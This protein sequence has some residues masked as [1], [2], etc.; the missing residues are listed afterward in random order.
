MGSRW[1]V[2][3]SKANLPFKRDFIKLRGYCSALLHRRQIFSNK[4]IVDCKLNHPILLIESYGLFPTAHPLS[5]ANCLQFSTALQPFAKMPHRDPHQLYT[6]FYNVLHL[7]KSSMARPNLVTATIAHCLAIKI[8]ALAHLPACNSLLTAYSRAKDFN[9]SLAF[10]DELYDKDVILWNA[11]ISA[12]VENN[13]YGLAMQLFLEMTQAGGAFD[14]TTLLLIV[15]ALSHMKCLK[16]GKSFHCLSI[17]SG[18]LRD[19]SLCNAL[20]DMYAKCGDLISSESM[21]AWMECRDVVSWNSIINGFLYTGLPA[22]SLWYFREM[23]NLGIRGDS[24]SLSCA[25][26]ASAALEELSSGQAIHAWGIKKG[27]TSDISCS[28]SLI[29]L[30]SQYG[31]TEA[32]ESVFEEMVHKD[33][34]SW[35]A[36]IGGFASN[37]KILETFD[38]LCKMQLT[39]YAQP[40]VATIVTIISVC[41]EW[42]LLREGR[43]IHGYAIRK[44]LISDVWVINSLLDMYSKCKCVVKA[45]FLFNTIP[46]RDLV[47]WNTMISGYGRNGHSKEAQSLFKKLLHQYSLS[48]LSTVLAV[49]SSCISPNSLWF[50]KSIHCWQIKAGFSSNTLAVNSLMHMYISYGDLS[51]SFMLLKK[52]SAGED[53]ACWNTIIVGCTRNDRFW[54]ALATFNWMRQE[55]S[56]KYDSITLVNVISA[57]GNLSLIHEGKS[58][59]SLAIKTF[60]GSETRVQN[61]LITM[62]G[63]CGHTESASSVFDFCSSRNLCSWNCM[64]SAFSQNKDGRRALELFHFLEFEPDEITIVA[65]LSACNQFGFLRQ[66]KQIQGHVMRLGFFENPFISAS[67]LDMYSSCGRLDIACQIFTMSKEKSIAGWNSMISAYGCHGN[68]KRAVQVFHEMCESGIRPSK[69]TFINLI[70]ACS[71]S[72]LVNE[73]LL[74]YSLMLGEYGVEPVTEHHVCIVDM[75]GRAG[76]LQEAYEFIK[77]IPK[78]PEPGV[79]GALLSACNYHGNIE[80]GRKVAEHVFGLEPDNVGYYISLANMYVSAGGWKDAMEL[81]QIIQDRKLRKLAAYSVIDVASGRF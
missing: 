15:S 29:S 54:E 67:L 47:S 58:L 44:Q 20:L 75:L 32:S 31:D 41:A 37:G 42:M 60:V 46:K 34:I 3:S 49:I 25:I 23:I 71:H 77:Q 53:I 79:W 14:S 12:A 59:H 16:N 24:V 68:G 11:I 39:G 69:S 61:A 27:H 10:F 6:H 52:I 55:T 38:M 50:G 17:K 78:E 33:V 73:G 22:K 35:N 18:M 43:T 45:E 40:D 51:A 7:L 9:S 80:M 66:G 2:M 13:F 74:H 76:K 28:N 81:R 72:G 26:S 70:S 5:I 56:V 65:L 30:Y 36:M 8:G 21:F 1:A 19:C 48:S 62:Y 64:I 57:C 4:I 63:R